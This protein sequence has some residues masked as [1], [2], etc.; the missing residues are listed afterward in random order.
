MKRNWLEW[1]V[2]VAS[3]AAIVLLVAVLTASGLVGGSRPPSPTIELHPE[4]GR[5]APAGW[6]V[7]ATVRNDGDIAA[8][9][10]V[11]EASAMVAG[12]EEV[13]ELEVDYL[14]PGTEVD[15]EFAFSGRPDTDISVRVVG[16]RPSG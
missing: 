1:I 11:V 8:E 13:S 15:I 16:M 7:P 5:D 9:A 6:I 12:E 10:V 3:A 4:E 2:L 14:P